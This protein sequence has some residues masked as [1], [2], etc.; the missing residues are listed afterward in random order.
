[1]PVILPRLITPV[2]E[3]ALG[4]APVVVLEGGR[5]T[6]KSTVCDELIRRHG[7]APRID[8]SDPHLRATLRLDPDRYLS[9]QPSVCVLDEAQLEPELTIWVKRQVDVRR[10]PGQFL[11]TGSARLGREQLGGS[12]PLA[13]RAVRLRMSSM[14]RAER[15]DALG[16]S[17]GVERAFADGWP[18]GQAGARPPRATPGADWAGGLP[19]IAGVL[20]EAPVAD[21]ERA[22][23]AYVEAVLPLGAGQTRADLGRLLRT[24]RYFAANSGQIANLAR[25][26]SELGLQAATVRSQLEILEAG[27]LVRRAEAERPAEHRVVTAHPRVFAADIGLAAWA[28]RARLTSPSATTLGALAE[29]AVAHDL[30]AQADA[31]A[32]RIEVRHWRDTRSQREVDLLLVHPDGRYVPVEVKASTVVGPGDAQGLAHFA[33]THPERCHRGVLVYEGERVVDL[34]PAGSPREIVAVPRVLL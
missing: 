33:R 6:G 7:W 18:H 25:A 17:R 29:T 5:A 24:F 14:T 26:A 4:T 10:A 11:I 12:D 9:A 13:G 21:W 19:S 28:S 22:M 31:S 23:A 8:L 30:M 15:A 16:E 3:S 1:M 27:F 32:H 34:T 2:I 20:T